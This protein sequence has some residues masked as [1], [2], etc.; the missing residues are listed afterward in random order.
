M[1]ILFFNSL[2][3]FRIQAPEKEIKKQKMFPD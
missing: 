1:S 3:L 2:Q